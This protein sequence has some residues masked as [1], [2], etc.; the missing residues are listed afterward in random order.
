MYFSLWLFC[1]GRQ[2][3]E[4]GREEKQLKHATKIYRQSKENLNYNDLSSA[5]Y[6]NK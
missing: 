3:E 2:K 4:K 6:K 5:K 1:E